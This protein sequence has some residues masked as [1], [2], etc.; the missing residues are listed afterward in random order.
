MV[1]SRRCA[2][3]EP[4]DLALVEVRRV[5]RRRV[6]KLIEEQFGAAVWVQGVV[7]R[8]TSLVRATLTR[9]FVPWP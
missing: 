9:A 2:A 8:Q 7:A 1:S 6:K 3:S 4:G 5:A